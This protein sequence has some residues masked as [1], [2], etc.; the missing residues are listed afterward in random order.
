[1]VMVMVIVMVMVR[2]TGQARLSGVFLHK[3]KVLLNIL[4]DEKRTGLPV[5]S[6]S[7]DAQSLFQHVDELLH[8]LH[9]SLAGEGDVVLWHHLDLRAGEGVALPLQ[10]LH[11]IVEGVGVAGD[12]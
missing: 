8:V 2:G 6:L 9:V 3:R 12:L 10:G 1:M 11:H 4:E 5:L 7:S